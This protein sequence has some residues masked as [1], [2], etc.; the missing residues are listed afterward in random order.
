MNTHIKPDGYD[1]RKSKVSNDVME[2]WRTCTITGNLQQVPGIGPAA[3]AKLADPGVDDVSIHNTWQLFGQY[4]M[5]KGPKDDNGDSHETID[6]FDHTE[7][8]WYFLKS[9]GISAHRS[10]IVKVSSSE[11][12]CVMCAMC[13]ADLNVHGVVTTL[14][15]PTVDDCIVCYSY[16]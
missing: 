3:A 13:T 16:D 9:K 6:P 11:C 2:T 8:F 10:A 4:L 5:L 14:E 12:V 7:R 15:R 1:P